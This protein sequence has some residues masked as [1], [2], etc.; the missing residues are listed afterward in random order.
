MQTVRLSQR[1]SLIQPSPT[2]AMTAKAREMRSAGIDVVSLAAGEPDFDTPLPVAEAAIDALRSGLTRY[3]PTKGL[4]DLRDAVQEKVARENGFT[5][6]DN[7]IVVTCGAKQALF[8]SL[9]CLAGPGDEVVLFTPCWMTYEEQ[10]RLSGA[11]PVYVPCRPEA[12]Y[13]PDHGEFMAAITPN[14]RV[15]VINSP[16]NPTGAVWP[17]ALLKSVADTCAERDIWIISDEIYERLIY[18]TS[19]Q[20]VAAFS[21]E[22]RAKTITILGCSKTYAMTGW[23]IGFSISPAPVAT[24]MSNLQDQ[25][26]S[27][28]TS[29]AQAGAV[30]ALKMPDSEIEAI[31]QSY[32]SRRDLLVGLVGQVPGLRASVPSGAFYLFVDVSE[33]LG[34]QV[35]SDLQLANRLLEHNHIA[36]IPGSV[37]HGPNHLRLSYAASEADIARG[38]ERIAAGL[39]AIRA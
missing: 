32:Q 2:L 22:V 8:N 19:H 10:V 31:R 25:V 7:E 16:C 15:V 5:C 1:A 3:L 13:V 33:F 37:F 28:A 34:G 12:G 9:M 38:F 21:P 14:T 30:A 36:T 4:P 23:R 20:S 29:F 35:D 11:E 27:N 17:A 26:T 24:A 18:G 39:E 6:Q